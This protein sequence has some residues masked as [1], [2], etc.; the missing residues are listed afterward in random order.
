MPVLGQRLGEL[1]AQAVQLDVLPVGVGLEELGGGRGDLR[2]HRHDVEGHDIGAALGQHGL[3][4][5]EEVRQAQVPVAVLAR[6]GQPVQLD[7]LPAVLQRALPR[8]RQPGRVEDHQLVALG[9][10][11]VVPVDDRGPE[12]ALGV[13]PVQPHPQPRPTLNLY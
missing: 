11:R 1:D 2:A 4:R 5:S 13:D 7:W 3:A 9:P 6:E 8:L 10:A 12:Q